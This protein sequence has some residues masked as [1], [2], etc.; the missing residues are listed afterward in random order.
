M[1]IE[2]LGYFFGVS[3]GGRGATGDTPDASVC[4]SRFLCATHLAAPSGSQYL[5]S[6]KVMKL[7]LNHQRSVQRD[8]S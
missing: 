8:F 4:P 3:I 1:L 6:Y 5:P 2:S 7:D